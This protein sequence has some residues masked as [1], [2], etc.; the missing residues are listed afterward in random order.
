[1]QLAQIQAAL[2]KAEEQHASAMTATATE[3]TERQAQFESKLSQ[4]AATRDEFKRRLNDTETALTVAQR[5][6]TAA[7]TEVERLTQ[8][9]AELTSQLAEGAAIR[10]DVEQRLA[11][12]EVSLREAK[13]LHASAMTAAATE[14]AA[15]QAQFERELSL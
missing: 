4:T 2:R 7:A 9:E 12:V 13:E 10:R 11:H 3:R 6:H 15:R 1:S 14:R 5:D 8:R